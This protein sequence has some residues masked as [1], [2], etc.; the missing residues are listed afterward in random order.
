MPG[1]IAT[2][3]S[4]VLCPH[5]AQAKPAAPPSPRVKI[6]G[7]PVVTVANT[8]AV[9]GCP[10]PPPPPPTN[11]GPCITGAW[12]PAPSR[13]KVQGQ[14]VVFR[15]STALVTPPVNGVLTV[16]LTQFRVKGS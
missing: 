16:K 9:Q 15:N 1:Y 8:F 2:A 5:M 12:V 10:N 7:Q 13:V 4:I 11:T 3:G 14:S 6:S